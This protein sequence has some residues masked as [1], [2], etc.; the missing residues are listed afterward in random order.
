[1]LDMM[2]LDNEKWGTLLGWPDADNIPLMEMLQD[3]MGMGNS[4]LLGASLRFH[5]KFHDNLSLIRSQ[6]QRVKRAS[7]FGLGS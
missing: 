6:K 3:P 1:M 5:F 4:T 2:D 7:S